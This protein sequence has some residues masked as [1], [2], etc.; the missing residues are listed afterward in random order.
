MVKQLRKKLIVAYVLAT[1]LLLTVIVAGLLFLSFKQYEN[2]NIR[3]YQASF[4]N[5]VDAVKDSSKITHAWLS[6]SEINEN[7]KNILLGDGKGIW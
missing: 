4:G 2:N 7:I 3:G 5:V 6:E 1:G